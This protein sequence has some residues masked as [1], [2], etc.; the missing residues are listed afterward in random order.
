MLSPNLVPSPEQISN[1]NEQQNPIFEVTSPL[2]PVSQ[3]RVDTKTI[4]NI[5][6]FFVLLAISLGLFGSVSRNILLHSFGAAFLIA[7]IIPLIL[8]I[9][10]VLTGASMFRKMNILKTVISSII[11][12]IGIILVTIANEQNRPIVGYALFATAL[13]MIITKYFFFVEDEQIRIQRLERELRKAKQSAGMGMALSYFYKFIVPT[14]ANIRSLDDGSTPIDMEIA[15][16]KFEEYQLNNGKL[17]VIVPRDLDGSDMKIFLKRISSLP[18]PAVMQGKPKERPG[19]DTHRPMFVYFLECNTEKKECNGLFD[20]PTIISSCWD[21][22]K[23]EQHHRRYTVNVADEIIIFQNQLISL[24]NEHPITRGK[25]RIL[26]FPSLPFRFEDI[27]Y[28]VT[29]LSH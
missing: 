28:A 14:A 21:R 23:N 12:I 6:L 24:I 4:L 3:R 9:W 27:K 5:V 11:L 25:V 13:L 16:G 7:G 2:E 1:I 20:I 17:F 22:H 26:S 15:R 8:T 29:Q 18:N 10:L 19:N